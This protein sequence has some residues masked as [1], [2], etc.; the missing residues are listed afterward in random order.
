MLRNLML[1]TRTMSDERFGAM[2]RDFYARYRGRRA[3]TRDFQQVVEEHVGRPMGW[4]F[5]EWVNGT[6]LP[7][8]TLAWTDSVRADSTHL[9]RFRVRQEGVPPGFSMYVPLLIL[10]SDSRQLIVRINVRGRA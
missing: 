2:M 4:F 5:D 9:L 7:T 3:S 6:A 8:Y 10:M 1:D